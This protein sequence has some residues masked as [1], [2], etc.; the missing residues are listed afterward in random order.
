VLAGIFVAI[1][2]S[3]ADFVRRA[4]RPHDAVPE[5]R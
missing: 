2:L 5:P 4:W 3:L 1:L